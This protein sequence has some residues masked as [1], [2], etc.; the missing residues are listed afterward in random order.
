MLW[1]GG[2]G[3][4][5]IFVSFC[6]KCIFFLFRSYYFGMFSGIFCQICAMHNIPKT[7]HMHVP[8]M[9]ERCAATYICVILCE[10]QFFLIQ[11][12]LF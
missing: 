4:T 8:R 6:V 7:A 11:V 2:F 10:V 12:I 1:C 9:P 5:Y 3:K